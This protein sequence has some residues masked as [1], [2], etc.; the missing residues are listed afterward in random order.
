MKLKRALCFLSMLLAATAISS[1]TSTVTLDATLQG[2][3][4]CAGLAGLTPTS[5][6]SVDSPKIQ[7]LLGPGTYI[8]TDNTLG[9]NQAWN[10]HYDTGSTSNGNWEW[11]FGAAIDSSGVVLLEDYAGT[12]PGTLAYFTSQAAITGANNL[13]IYHGNTLPAAA[14]Q[15]SGET[16]LASFSDTLT[17][18]SSTLV[19]FYVLDTNLPDNL[20]GMS[21]TVTQQSTGTPEPAIPLLIGTGLAAIALY[22]RKRQ[23][24]LG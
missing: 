10:F 17:L 4:S 8:I 3:T 24:R 18:T 12:A 11:S 20:G 19:D 13:Q 9:T 23:S 15:L 16:S 7:F 1:A 2:C 21:L 6:I 22:R 14:T 5:V